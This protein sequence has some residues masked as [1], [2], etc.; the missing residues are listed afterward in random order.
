MTDQRRPDAAVAAAGLNRHRAEEQRGLTAGTGNVPK[1][2]GAD[3]ALCLYGHK[4]EAVDR[5]TAGAQP[6]GGFPPPLCAAKG[7]VEQRLTRLNVGG[8]LIPVG[9]H[10]CSYPAG[11]REV[12]RARE[13][14]Q[15]ELEEM[16]RRG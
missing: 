15:F 16:R 7:L 12:A 11:G 10:R 4:S 6:L 8:P 1:P 2:G 5:Q 3:D 9:D 14:R 13:R